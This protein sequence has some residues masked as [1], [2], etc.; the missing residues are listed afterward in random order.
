MGGGV[1]V[2]YLSASTAFSD[3]LVVVSCGKGGSHASERVCVPSP[4][5]HT[6]Q[7]RGVGHKWTLGRPYLF[8]TPISAKYKNYLLLNTLY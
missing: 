3:F 2:R 1:V 5:L 7:Y 4:K 6:V 8:S